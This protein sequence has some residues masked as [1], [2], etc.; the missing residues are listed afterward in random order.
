MEKLGARMTNFP[1]DLIELTVEKKQLK[2]NKQT[3]KMD[4][5]L[6]KSKL[7]IGLNL[8]ESSGCSGIM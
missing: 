2:K 1:A 5:F 3:C 4:S 7:L 8:I 6:F